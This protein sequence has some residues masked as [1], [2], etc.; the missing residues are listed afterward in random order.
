MQL[1]SKRWTIKRSFLWRHENKPS[2]IKASISPHWNDSD[3]KTKDLRCS[4][5]LSDIE[6]ASLKNYVLKLR[7]HL[8]SAYRLTQLGF[9][10][11]FNYQRHI[12]SC[13]FSG[14]FGSPLVLAYLL[15]FT[16]Y[17]TLPR[18]S[19]TNGELHLTHS[20]HSLRRSIN[21]WSHAA[22]VIGQSLSW[23]KVSNFCSLL[24]WQ[25]KTDFKY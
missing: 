23:A 20:A 6:I 18:N 19:S 16:L 17:Q 3:T 5:V 21:K 15:G 4:T 7:L 13:R 11:Y 10:I 22:A 1:T 25:E 8:T 12:N 14:I 9:S 24:L 2:S